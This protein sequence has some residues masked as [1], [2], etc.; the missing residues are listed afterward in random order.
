MLLKEIIIVD[1]LM[2]NQG[3]TGSFIAKKHNL[4]Q[5][6]VSNYLNSLEKEQILKSKIQGKN[7]LYY[8]ID[9]I[10][11]KNFL[12]S[13]ELNKTINFYKKHVL[14]KEVI[15][16]LK[17][18]GIAII[19]GSYAKGIEK[20]KSDLDLFVIGKCDEKEIHK[21]GDMYKLEINL[22]IYPKFEL[23]I[24]TKEVVKNHIIIKGVEEW[25]KLVGV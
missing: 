24:L 15:S 17:I 23:D 3:I 19:F 2:R 25:I 18:K 9:D 4:N 21:I 16:K 13:I 10:N 8:F 5:K 1:E 6:T 20:K 7:K 12:M 11:T 22:K 14:V